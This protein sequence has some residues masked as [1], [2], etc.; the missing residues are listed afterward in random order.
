LSYQA[1]AVGGVILLVVAVVI[2][3]GQ[4]SKKETASKDFGTREGP[5]PNA[6]MAPRWT[7]TSADSSNWQSGAPNSG[8]EA[9]ELAT[10]PPKIEIPL[11]SAKTPAET[12]TAAMP[13]GSYT[14]R[15]GDLAANEQ[16]MPD[17][18]TQPY[19]NT[20]EKQPL[21][22]SWSDRGPVTGYAAQQ[23]APRRDLSRQTAAGSTRA[24]FYDDRAPAGSTNPA[25][26]NDYQNRDYPPSSNDAASQRRYGSSYDTAPPAS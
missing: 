5:A 22:P 11:G 26:Y 24:A 17:W 1:I 16:T 19:P 20:A 8:Q 7:G 9:V 6:P 14:A 15:N 23:T 18:R 3:A 12:T 2:V 4:R 10:S 13:D 21:P 25:S